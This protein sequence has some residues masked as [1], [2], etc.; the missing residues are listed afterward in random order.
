MDSVV[1]RSLD[2]EA[3]LAWL[4]RMAADVGAARAE[5]REV[6]LFG[7][8]ARGDRNP[9]ADADLLIVVD[10]AEAV[11]RDRAPRYRP[12]SAPVPL[13]LLVC[14]QAELDRERA[15]GNA[16]VASILAESLTLYRRP[17]H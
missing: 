9:Y 16:F 5:V 6:R 8:L 11:F 7:S 1:A 15:A 2:R 14:T 17:P 10:R 12:D 3:V 13:D 4:T